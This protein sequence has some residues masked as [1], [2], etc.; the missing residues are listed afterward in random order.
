DCSSKGLPL[1]FAAGARGGYQFIRGFSGE[2]AFGFMYMGEKLTRKVTANAEHDAVMQSSNYKDQTTFGG[3][4]VELSA[5]YQMLDK[6][7]LTFRLGGGV[8]RAKAS[9]KNEGTFTGD[10]PH[11]CENAPDTCDD[12]ETVSVTKK[13]S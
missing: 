1:G 3:P 5:A 4:F 6:T 9:F 7:P 12:T 2:L 13:V 10:I 11:V 8:A